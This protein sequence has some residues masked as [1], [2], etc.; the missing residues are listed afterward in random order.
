[1]LSSKFLSKLGVMAMPWLCTLAGCGGDDSARTPRGVK[2]GQTTEFLVPQFPGG[3][4]SGTADS[5]GAGIDTIGCGPDT[6]PAS[7]TSGPAPGE[8]VTMMCFYSAEQVP[9]STIEWVVET[10]Q[11]EE[12]VHIRQTFNPDFVDNSYGETQ[13]GWTADAP[14]DGRKG[15]GRGRKGRRGHRFKDL[16]GSDHT[17]IQLTD[18]HGDVV[19]DFKVDYLSEKESAISGYAT[20]GV[21]DGDGK[22]ITGDQSAVVAVSTSLDR[23]LNL[24]GLS[25]Y[26][27]NSPPTTD[28][29][30]P[31]LEAPEWDYRVVY[32][33]WVQ[34]DVFGDAGFGEALIDHVHASPSKAGKSTIEVTPGDCPPDWC[35]RPEGCDETDEPPDEDEPCGTLLDQDCGGGEPPTPV[36]CDEQPQLCS[37]PQ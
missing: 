27:E 30:A 10:A 6:T 29:Y 25:E 8:K 20:L 3:G 37:R 12:L 36:D 19:L 33:V 24:C 16:V 17:Q 1:M 31:S 23:N 4:T 18:G 5:I 21:E 32:D 13:I 9:A 35:D 7:P 34:L 28:D 2:A 11:N 26:T 15:K 14:Q 22:V